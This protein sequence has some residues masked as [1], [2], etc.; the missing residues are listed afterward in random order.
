MKTYFVAEVFL[1]LVEPQH[2]SVLH[3]RKR[4]CVSGDLQAQQRAGSKRG[5]TDKYYC[6]CERVGNRV[7]VLL[8]GG[9]ID[10]KICR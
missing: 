9:A 10:D 7:M 2:C 3:V 1:L 4:W 8:G 6:L 5:R